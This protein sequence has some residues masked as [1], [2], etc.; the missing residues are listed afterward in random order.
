MGPMFDDECLLFGSI[1]VA[2]LVATV[3]VLKFGMF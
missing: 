1:V 2:M 3:L